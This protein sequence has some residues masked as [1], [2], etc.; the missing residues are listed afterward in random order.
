[1]REWYCKA[2][3]TP[4]KQEGGT[5]RE[6]IL[7]IR[8]KVG[9]S[10]HEPFFYLTPEGADQILALLCEEV[11]KALAGKEEGINPV[12]EAEYHE[13]WYDCK[14]WIFRVLRGDNDRP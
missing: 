5:M 12:S 9:A 11:E 2:N 1:M 10:V 6:K 4:G 7:A 14:H 3:E 8:P 13:G